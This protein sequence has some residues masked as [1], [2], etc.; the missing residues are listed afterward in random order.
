MRNTTTPRIFIAAT[1]QNDGKTTVSLG[2]M[3]GLRQYFSRV[4]YIKPV[5]QRFVEV[6]EQ[7]IDE[8]TILMD[9]VFA[10]NCPLV[11]MSPIAVEPDFTR[12]YIQSSNREALVG[13]IERAFDRVA[14]EK[15]F[16]LCEGSGHAGVGSVFDLSNAQIAKLLNAKVIIVTQGG[17][18]RPIDEVALNQALFEKEGVE[19][20]GII[21]N[22]ISQ[23][24]LEFIEEFTRRG[25]KRR[26]LELLGAIP[27]QRILSS[28]TMNLIQRELHA[29][30]LNH[31]RQLNNLVQ[32]IVVGAMGVH[33][34]LRFFKPGALLITPGDRLDIVLTVAGEGSEK[35][36]LKLAGIILTDN[37]R[38]SRNI[39]KVIEDMPFPVLLAE[40]DSYKVTSIV[41]DLTVKTTPDDA[42]KISII[43]D[44]VAKH[45]D[46]EK[47]WKSL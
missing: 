3:T 30:M 36:D 23:E 13:T 34:A 38:P 4:G 42:E 2:L 21:V 10:L 26:G 24:K 1:R 37:A 20:M 14:W 6:E 44:L 31:S 33:N 7:K 39:M 12:R 35:G 28:P 9:R 19:I 8:D 27:H 43:R 5:G 47:I 32:D 40:A 15:D 29:E 25:F 45:V 17:I 22:K 41:H 46:V 16:V 18:G 11:D